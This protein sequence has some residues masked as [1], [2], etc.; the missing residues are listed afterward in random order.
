M[1]HDLELQMVIAPLGE[2]MLGSLDTRLGK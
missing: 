2:S 1:L